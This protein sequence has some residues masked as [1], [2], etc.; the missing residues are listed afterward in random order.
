MAIKRYYLTKDN[1]IS[2]AFKSNLTSRGVSGNMGQSD[3]VEIFSIYAQ[4][5]TSSS[6]LSRILIEFDTTEINTDRTNGVIPASG[7]VNYFLR[8][9]NARHSQ[10]TPKDYTLVYYNLSHDIY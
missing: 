9:Y 8:L 2:N 10:T 1:T 5:N 6:E 4:A 3:I 7:S